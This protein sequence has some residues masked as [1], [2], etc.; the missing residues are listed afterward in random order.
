MK[1]L[2]MGTGEF[3]VPAFA[4]LADGPHQV[5]GLVTQ[6]DRGG[7]GHH[8]HRHPLELIKSACLQQGVP[9]RVGAQ[10]PSPRAS[11]LHLL[12]LRGDALL[13]ENPQDFPKFI[14]EIQDEHPKTLFVEETVPTARETIN[15]ATN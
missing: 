3:A 4:A 15:G 11:L 2:L 14:E 9:V 7:P 13:R 12:L 6:P 5:V 1:L 10:D 8:D